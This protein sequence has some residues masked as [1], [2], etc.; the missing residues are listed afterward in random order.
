MSYADVYCRRC[1]S[2]MHV[3]CRLSGEPDREVLTGAV[4][5]CTKCKRVV[6]IMQ[7]TEYKVASQVDSEGKWYR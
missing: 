2:S 7:L 6:T 5:K 4:M 3:S 1:K